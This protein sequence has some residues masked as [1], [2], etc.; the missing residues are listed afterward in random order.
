MGKEAGLSSLKIYSDHGGYAISSD[1]KQKFGLTKTAAV[2]HLVS[3]YGISAP[4]AKLMVSESS[5]KQGFAPKSN[6]YML[7]VAERYSLQTAQPGSGSRRV[8]SQA[9]LETNNE[10]MPARALE[11]AVKASDSGVKEVMDV[12]ILAGL[13]SSKQSLE[14]IGEYVGDLIKAMDRLGRMLFLFYWRNE[15]FKDHY[16]QQDLIKLEDSLRDVFSSTGDLIIFLREKSVDF[17]TLFSSNKQSVSDDL[18]NM[19]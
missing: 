14:M 3:D 15:D 12:S 13:A 7:K 16:G 11:A 19:E 8:F 5:D 17:D 9:P 2:L 6:R 4:S 1:S 18:G 10:L